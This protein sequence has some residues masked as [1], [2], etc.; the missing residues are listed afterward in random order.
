M[1]PNE[2]TG[3]HECRFPPANLPVTGDLPVLR[4]AELHAL[5]SGGR[6]RIH[7]AAGGIATFSFHRDGLVTGDFPDGTRDRGAWRLED[8][9]YCIDWERG[10]KGS[11]TLVYR[12]GQ[13]LVLRDPA[14]A[15]RGTV[16]TSPTA[17]VRGIV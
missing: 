13:A 9:R 11:C 5:L 16:D 3:T 1:D 8:D 7:V 4:A 14:G 12:D 17:T 15:T 6:L 10:P 2:T